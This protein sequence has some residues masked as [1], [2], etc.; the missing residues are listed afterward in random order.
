ME[1]LTSVALVRDPLPR[2]QRTALIVRPR[3]SGIIARDSASSHSKSILVLEL[4]AEGYDPDR[5]V[6]VHMNGGPRNYLL[7]RNVRWAELP[8]VEKP[9]FDYGVCYVFRHFVTEDGDICSTNEHRIYDDTVH[10]SVPDDEGIR[11][12]RRALRKDLSTVDHV[13]VLADGCD[14]RLIWEAV[15]PVWSARG[16]T[17][18]VTLA[19]GKNLMD[20][21]ALR[22]EDVAVLEKKFRGHDRFMANYMFNMLAIG[23]RARFQ[24]A[25]ETGLPALAWHEGRLYNEDSPADSHD[26]HA[27]ATPAALQF[28]RAFAE[29]GDPVALGSADD[30]ERF[31]FP[32]GL[33][34]SSFYAREGDN[35]VFVWT[36]TG[37]HRPIRMEVG[38]W[39]DGHFRFNQADTGEQ[40]PHVTA[41][42][43]GAGLVVPFEGRTRITPEGVRLLELLG[44]E[45]DDP[46]L[47]LRW[48]TEDGLFAS[49]TDIPSCDRWLHRKFRELKRRLASLPSSPF[50][51]PEIPLSLPTRKLVVR[52]LKYD[53]RR[54]SKMER[55]A[56][57]KRVES[58]ASRIPLGRRKMGI[59][60]PLFGT[61]PE[62]LWIGHPLET[63]KLNQPLYRRFDDN[64][65]TE[66]WDDFYERNLSLVPPELT[67]VEPEGPRFMTTPVLDGELPRRHLRHRF[68]LKD[69]MRIGHLRYGKVIFID[70]LD[71]WRLSGR[72]RT[73][74]MGIWAG[75][76]EGAPQRAEGFW[77]FGGRGWQTKGIFFGRTVGLSAGTTRALGRDVSEF[78]PV[79]HVLDLDRMRP[80]EDPTIDDGQVA[81]AL[82]RAEVHLWCFEG[83]DG[84]TIRPATYDAAAG[85]VS[86]GEYWQARTA[87]DPEYARQQEEMR[88]ERFTC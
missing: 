85:I 43:G 42:L 74:G 36:G 1:R 32:H 8:I 37:K 49:E 52:G 68:E 35:L 73:L 78:A 53:L 59:L 67:H 64:V 21:S 3:S 14:S 28:L 62:G 38:R 83:R 17:F 11:R 2:D 27:L 58:T 41:A 29:A 7:P 12:S 33:A 10:L 47:I 50:S 6:L 71:D 15:A 75:L 55:D 20:R 45:M 57:V 22:P 19:T 31:D 48:R 34:L 81:A 79:E 30:Y 69:G 80:L 86:L 60:Y 26:E 25:R 51:E 54:L 46:D 61:E 70:D 40:Y 66:V 56:L 63:M 5:I 44:P 13:T 65:D 16:S 4:M 88:R 39:K 84:R 72:L 77:D 9:V 76:E 18:T 82:A 24:V 87:R 23:G